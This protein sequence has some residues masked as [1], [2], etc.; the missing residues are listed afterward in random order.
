MGRARARHKIEEDLK[1]GVSAAQLKK[2][3]K[4]I[5]PEKDS[6]DFIDALAEP[7][8]YK[9]AEKALAGVQ[10]RVGRFSTALARKKSSRC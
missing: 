5:Y 10:C 7:D 1:N 8:I 4:D 3:L 2:R 6:H 9:L